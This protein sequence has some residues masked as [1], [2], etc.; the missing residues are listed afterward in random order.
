MH[1][2]CVIN[3]VTIVFVG[4]GVM[5]YGLEGLATVLI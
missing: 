5:L 4:E 3:V 2:N 1:Y